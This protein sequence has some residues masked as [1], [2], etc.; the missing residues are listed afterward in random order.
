MKAA[1]MTELASP[2][3]L[4]YADVTDPEPVPVN[5][6]V[7]MNVAALDRP[8]AVWRRVGATPRCRAATSSARFCSEL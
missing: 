5:M 4:E 7:D 8:D 3:V 6:A 1:V 2:E